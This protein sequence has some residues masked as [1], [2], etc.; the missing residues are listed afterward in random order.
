MCCSD[1]GTRYN[2]ILLNMHGQSRQSA[3][4]RILLAPRMY[5]VAATIDIDLDALFSVRYWLSHASGKSQGDWEQLTLAPRN[6]NTIAASFSR[7]TWYCA[8]KPPSRDHPGPW[9]S[10]DGSVTA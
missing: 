7:V 10:N 9:S 1:V 8:G 3:C 5:D 4:Y 2:Q 6:L